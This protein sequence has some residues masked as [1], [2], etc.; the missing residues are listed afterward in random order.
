MRKELWIDPIREIRCIESVAES[1]KKAGYNA[2]NSIVVTVSTDY[3]SIAGQIIRHELTHEGEIAD[4]F[5]VDVPYPDQE[6]DTKFVNE[7]CSM[8]LLHKQAIGLKTVILVEAGVIRG[9]NYK[10][11]INLMQR[12]LEM[13]NPIVTTSLFENKH[14]AFKCDHIAEYYDDEVEDLTFWWEKENNH[15]K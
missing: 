13:D 6:W 7:A 10:S 14:S 1:L 3:S 2:S 12:V 15:W 4:G 5:G 8:F 9:S 11:L